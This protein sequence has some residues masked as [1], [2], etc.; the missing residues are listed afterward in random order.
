[1]KRISSLCIVLLFS[2]MAFAQTDITKFLGIPIDGTKTQMIQKLKAKGFVYSAIDDVLTGE[3]NGSNVELH[4]VTNN[5][6]V[7][8][9]V[10]VEKLGIEESDVKIRFNTLCNQFIK[11][12]KYAQ[13]NPF[14]DY[15]IG[16]DV[17]ISYEMT[18]KNKRFEASYFQVTEADMDTT[19]MGLW[20]K[21]KFRTKYGDNFVNNVS[22]EELFEVG[23]E[24]T[25][26]YLYEK[27]S[28]KSVWF[29]I[30]K[31]Y[32][33]YYIY[34]YYDNKNNMANGEDL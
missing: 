1:M 24:L 23:I 30:S 31:H 21:S 6:K 2:V 8:R 28:H 15:I 14:D 16:E 12:G 32:L 19:G 34:I 17:D 9:I 26:K 25:I 10:V 11:N 18:V 22:E 33:N 29:M 20:M 4:V 3:F 5:N 7:Y 13:Q 27:I